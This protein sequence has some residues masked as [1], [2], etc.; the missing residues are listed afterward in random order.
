MLLSQLSTRS[1]VPQAL[2]NLRL[3]SHR[4]PSGGRT[5]FGRTLRRG[6]KR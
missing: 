3:S 5:E 2:A 6:R 4:V 1:P